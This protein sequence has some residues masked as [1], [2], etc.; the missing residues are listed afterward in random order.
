MLLFDTDVHAVNRSA[1]KLRNSNN[2]HT[3]YQICIN[4]NLTP[5]LRK[6]NN[7]LKISRP[8]AKQLLGQF[9]LFIMVGYLPGY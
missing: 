2:V 1:M 4:S 9:L 7:E 5:E 8:R 3:H 6:L